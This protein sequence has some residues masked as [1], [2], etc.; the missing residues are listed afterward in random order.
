VVRVILKHIKNLRAKL[1]GL[2][3]ELTD[4]QKEEILALLEDNQLSDLK[5][6]TSLGLTL[7]NLQDIMNEASPEQKEGLYIS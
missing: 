7:D 5:S 3:V 1:L 2:K 6:S 4:S